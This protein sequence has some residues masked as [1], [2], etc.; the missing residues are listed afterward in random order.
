[1]MALPAAYQRAIQEGKT[2]DA[3]IAVPAQ[4][5]NARS[6]RTNMAATPEFSCYLA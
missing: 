1:M 2:P 5:N 3:D 4:S 6:A